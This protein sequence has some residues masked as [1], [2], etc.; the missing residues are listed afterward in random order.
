[1]AQRPEAAPAPPR[2]VP[3]ARPPA[4]MKPAPA[5]R[6]APEDVDDELPALPGLVSLDDAP[7]LLS[8]PGQVGAAPAPER[9]VFATPKTAPAAPPRALAE[10]R[11]FDGFG[12][13]GDPTRTVVFDF[14]DLV[15]GSLK[16]SRESLVTNVNA[17][18]LAVLTYSQGAPKASVMIRQNTPL[19]AMHRNRF[20]TLKDNQTAVKVVVLE[21]ESKDPDACVRVGECL[22]TGLPA[23][24]KGQEV[25]IVYTYD[26]D[27][28]LA[29]LAR[30]VGSGASAE[31]ELRRATAMSAG[32]RQE[33]RATLEALGG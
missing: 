28:R 7:E 24:P 11:E 33:Q 30:D 27:G 21:G 13:P 6:L 20:F 2:A 3:A 19:P 26:Q 18:S 29:I 14:G 23:R 16:E 9:P 8:L 32:E 22:I 15:G 4:K 10:S 12:W 25:E 31:V 5:K 1:M 17:R